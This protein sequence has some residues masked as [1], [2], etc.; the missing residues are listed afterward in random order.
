MTFVGY[1][2]DS[3]AYRLLYTS[4]G[5]V[6]ISRDVRFLE[7]D[8]KG[9]SVKDGTIR[10]LPG[11]CYNDDEQVAVRLYDCGQTGEQ[12]PHDDSQDEEEF[13]GFEDDDDDG[14]IEAVP[15]QEEQ[16]VV[17]VARD[18]L[19]RS[20]RTN[21]GVPPARYDG[22]IGLA[23]S[24]YVSRSDCEPG[25]REVESCHGRGDGISS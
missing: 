22:T 8:E 19:R 7:L 25:K 14:F 24:R 13:F 5:Q 2:S 1:A 6:V 11:E 4:T 15:R 16:A 12:V 23:V 18:N 17:P 20:Q 10:D 21:F 9:K 3:K